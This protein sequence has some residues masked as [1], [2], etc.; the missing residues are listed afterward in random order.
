MIAHGIGPRELSIGL[1]GSRA[2]PGAGRILGVALLVD[3]VGTRLVEGSR[4][5]SDKFLWLVEKL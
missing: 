3:G 5:L 1:A 2:C 4:H